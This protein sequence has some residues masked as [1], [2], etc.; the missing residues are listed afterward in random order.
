[1]ADAIPQGYQNL[2]AYLTP[3]GAA[4]DHDMVGRGECASS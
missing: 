2:M 3:R 1:M 4:R